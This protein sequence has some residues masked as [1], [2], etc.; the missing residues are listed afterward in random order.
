MAHLFQAYLMVD[1]SAAAK[2]AT[3]ANSI[4]IGVMAR[5]ARLKFQF[6]AA[7]PPTRLKARAFLEEM[8]AKL[9]GRGDR[10]LLGFDFSLGYPVGTAAALGLDTDGQAPWAAMHA[11]LASKVREREDNSNA[12]F[13]IAAGLN[14]AISKGPAPFWGAPP[15][16]QV[17]T[18]ASR[19]PDFGSGDL[20]LAEFRLA[21]RRLRES[22]AGQPK[23]VWQLYGAGSVGSQS[24]LGIPHVHALRSAWP[25][26]RL[27]PFETGLAALDDEALE[28]TRVVIA[29]VYPALWP[30]RAETGETQDAAQVRTLCEQMRD[31]DARDALGAAFGPP[32]GLQSTEIA[33]IEREEGW[34]LGI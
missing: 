33:A 7:N 21:E 11:H 34:I 25:D 28:D 4:W 32:D 6:R 19:K 18:L 16:D 30:V 13:A 14:Y 23:S 2:P 8:V 12:R 10:V 17:S 3:G 27:W 9:T 15:R 22:R 20:A 1:W 5:D 24:L 29:E 26:A 31:L